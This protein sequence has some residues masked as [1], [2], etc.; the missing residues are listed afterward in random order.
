MLS[1]KEQ[2][3]VCDVTMLCLYNM[4]RRIVEQIEVW[5]RSKLT[6]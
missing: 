3:A 1:I 5:M 4:Y 6:V 2:S